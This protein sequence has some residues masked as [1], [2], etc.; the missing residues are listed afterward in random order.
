MKSSTFYSRH[1][2]EIPFSVELGQFEA[3]LGHLFVRDRN[4]CLVLAF[5]QGSFHDQA[6]GSTRSSD[7]VDH[8]LNIHQRLTTPV[9]S[10]EAEEPML[11]LVPLAGARWEMAHRQFQANLIG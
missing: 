2:V 4:T 3:K 6:F 11:H 1:D 9:L 8:H 7:E 10:Y 5:I